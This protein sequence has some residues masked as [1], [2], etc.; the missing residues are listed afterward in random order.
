MIQFG[1]TLRMMFM[2]NS[3]K[4][5]IVLVRYP[6]SDLSGAKDQNVFAVSGRQLAR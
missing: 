3:S 2:P 4:N 5:D 1:I 6:Y